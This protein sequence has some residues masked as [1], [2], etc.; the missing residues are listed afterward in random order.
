MDLIEGESLEARLQGG[1]LEPREAAQICKPLA[2]ALVHAHSHAILHRDIK[3]A[4][5]LLTPE[6]APVLTDFGLAK[7]MEE[8]QGLT[9]SG[10]IVGT[11]AYASP[12][13]ASGKIDQPKGRGVNS[14]QSKSKFPIFNRRKSIS[15][16]N[17]FNLD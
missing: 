8:T 3:P 4:N 9:L 16:E 12:E 6:G 15:T 13:Q 2:M 7:R 5:V 1:P 11:P 14:F 17:G 10:Q